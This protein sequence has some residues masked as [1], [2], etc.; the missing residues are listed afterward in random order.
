MKATYLLF[1]IAS[2][3]VLKQSTG[4]ARSSSAPS[5][6][7]SL[8]D[9]RKTASDPRGGAS[10]DGPAEHGKA[11]LSGSKSRQG[12]PEARARS[13]SR[14]QIQVRQQR[15]MRDAGAPG[16]SGEASKLLP[17]RRQLSLSESAASL[18]EPRSDEL[19]ALRPRGIAGNKRANVVSAVHT[20][21][22][23]RFTPPL[24]NV[25]HRGPNPGLIAGSSTGRVGSSGAING[26]QMKRRP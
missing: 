26:T 25:R 2:L 20:P 1:L 8:R 11:P 23:A 14:R 21:S 19:G 16:L 17:S 9:S 18:H 24:L 13:D 12:V 5:S 6:Q 4:Y 3:G 15:T 22:V 10:H 7:A